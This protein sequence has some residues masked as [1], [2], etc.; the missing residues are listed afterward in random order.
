MQVYK[1]KT[2]YVRYNELNS[3]W[4]LKVLQSRETDAVGSVESFA[5]GPEPYFVVIVFLMERVQMFRIVVDRD[6]LTWIHRRSH[7]CSTFWVLHNTQYVRRQPLI[8]SVITLVS[9]QE[10]I[11]RCMVLSRGDNYGV[12]FR[13]VMRREIAGRPSR[14]S[15]SRAGAD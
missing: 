14:R 10:L 15:A 8:L 3:P 12:C 11:A 9:Y 13:R 2:W 5:E 7:N 1:T 4:V 6:C